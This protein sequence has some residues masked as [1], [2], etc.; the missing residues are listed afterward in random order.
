MRLPRIA[1]IAGAVVLAATATAVAVAAPAQSSGIK[2]VPRYDHVVVAMFENKD[3]DTIIGSSDAPYFNELT[4]QGALMTQSFGVTH[5]SEPNYIALFSGSQQGVTDDACPADFPGTDNLGKQLLDAGLT[6]T[7]YSEDLPEVGFTGCTDGDYARKHAPWV[8]F[9]TVPANLN[10]PYSQFPSDYSQLPTVSFVTP[11]MCN[12]MHDCGVDT[13]DSWLREQP[14]RVRPVGQGEQQPAH[15]HV[16]RGQLQ[17]GE[18]DRH[19]PG[20][21]Q[22]H[23]GPVRRADQPLQ[24]AAHHRGHVRPARAGQRG[25]QGVD[26]EHLGHALVV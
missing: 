16:R 1:V 12:D 9:D 17:L 4:G 15:R 14:R 2:A 6:F 25:R 24:R 3:Y 22:H 23:A 18:P 11:D 5:P 19:G 7:G 13:G 10:V 26:R 21:R 20:R 8:D